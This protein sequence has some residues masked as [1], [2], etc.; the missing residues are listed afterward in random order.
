MVRSKSRLESLRLEREARRERVGEVELAVSSG[1]R[2]GRLV[3]ELE[4][5]A[6]SYGEKR[7]VDDFSGRVMRGDKVGLIGPNGSGK[8][9]LLKLVLGEIE[10]DAG[11]VR[12]G[13]KV[14]VA[15]FDPL[16]TALD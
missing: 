2:S 11:R 14:S 8:S 6:K 3:A 15:Y 12:L 1:E 16:R 13:S 7:V 5:V 4:H 10:P 9:T